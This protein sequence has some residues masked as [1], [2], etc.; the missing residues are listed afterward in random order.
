MA[1]ALSRV[2]VTRLMT[3][4]QWGQDRSGRLAPELPSISLVSNIVFILDL[5]DDHALGISLSIHLYNV[6]HQG[7]RTTSKS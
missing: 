6:Y 3:H 4:A 2:W 7:P 1:A 5:A